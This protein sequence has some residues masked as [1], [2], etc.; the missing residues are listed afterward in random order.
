MTERNFIV[1]IIKIDW[2]G[3]GNSEAEVLFELKGKQYWA[4]SQPCSFGEGEMA[5]VCFDFIE[6]EIP[7][8]S[9][10]SLN[11]EKKLEVIPLESRRCFYFCYGRVDNIHP[12]TIDC[13]VFNFTSGDWINDEKV[14]GSFVYFIISRLDITRISK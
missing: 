10:W 1:R 12:V 8:E 3:N 11:K 2:I 13:G 6:E 14:I 4:F 5:Q 7:E 9:F